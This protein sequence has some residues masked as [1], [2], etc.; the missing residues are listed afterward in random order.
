MFHF[1]VKRVDLAFNNVLNVCHRY[2][3]VRGGSDEKMKNIG[4]PVN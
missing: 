1:D 2:T 4:K 3:F